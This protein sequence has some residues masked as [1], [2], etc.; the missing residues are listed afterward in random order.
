MPKISL[1][2]WPWASVFS[3]YICILKTFIDKS[4]IYVFTNNKIDNK[5]EYFVTNRY[6]PKVDADQIQKK[7]SDYVLKQFSK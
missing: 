5:N 4:H 2:A 1:K 6:E 3:S 7:T